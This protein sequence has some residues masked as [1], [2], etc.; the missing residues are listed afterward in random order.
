MR[1]KISCLALTC[2]ILVLFNTDALGDRLFENS[3]NSEQRTQLV[4]EIQRD[5]ALEK[6]L[7]KI[8][9]LSPKESEWLKSELSSGDVNRLT[10][11]TLSHEGMTQK[12]RDTVERIDGF[13]KGLLKD[14]NKMDYWLLL[15]STLVTNDTTTSLVRVCEENIIQE[16]PLNNIEWIMGSLTSMYARTIIVGVIG[17][18]YGVSF[19]K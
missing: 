12:A 11:A 14:P 15:A 6:F 13:V 8:P 1:H 4:K 2:S 19:R 17:D 5:F 3:T 10:K 7:K 9:K 18:D 16:C